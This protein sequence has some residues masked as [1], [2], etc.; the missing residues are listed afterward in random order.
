MQVHQLL[1]KGKHCPRGVCSRLMSDE[2]LFTIWGGAI[3]EASIYDDIQ[4]AN[5]LITLHN[6]TLL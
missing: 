4:L 1:L 2:Y 5:Y 6:K 3:Q